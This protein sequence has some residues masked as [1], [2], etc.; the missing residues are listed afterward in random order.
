MKPFRPLLASTLESP[1]LLRFPVCVSPKLDGIRCS[2]VAGLALS[3]NGKEIPNRHIFGLLS[4]P[5]FHGLDGEL[6]VGAPNGTDVFNRTSSGVMSRDGEPD[7]TYWVFDNF[8]YPNA[9]YGQR[10]A[11]LTIFNETKTESKTPYIRLLPHRVIHTLNELAAYETEMLAAGFEGIMIRRP[12]GPYKE[13]RSTPNDGILRKLKR[14]R[15]GEATVTAV[16]EGVQNQNPATLDDL[17]YTTRSTHAAN[18]VGAGRVGTIIANDLATGA[19]LNISPGR[20]TH[21][22]R[23]KYF[24]MPQMIIGRVVKYKA[25]DYGAIDAPR[26]VT[27]QAF[28]DGQQ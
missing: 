18:M 7:F 24:L 11:M 5:V 28:L 3:R 4:H 9:G 20:L 17:G 16:L 13:G 19:Q 12:D 14:F 25:F 8:I 21:A 22:Q 10:Y 1:A 23:Q 15:D 26:F 27:F 6:I 2:I